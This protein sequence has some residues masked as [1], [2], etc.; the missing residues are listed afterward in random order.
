MW[1]RQVILAV[2]GAFDVYSQEVFDASFFLSDV[3]S[4]VRNLLYDLV[5]FLVIWSCQNGVVGVLV[6]NVHYVA[7]VED[8]LV[9]F[10]LRKSNHVHQFAS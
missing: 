3:E 6:E 4:G 2:A 10:T 1:L 7:L 9:V 8:A 5:Q